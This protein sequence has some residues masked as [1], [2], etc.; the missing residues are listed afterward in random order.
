MVQSMLLSPNYCC[1]Y[2]ILC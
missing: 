1:L 2:I